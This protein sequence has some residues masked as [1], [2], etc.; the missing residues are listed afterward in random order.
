[1]KK[2]FLSLLFVTAVS[3]KLPEAFAQDESSP[4]L[5]N[6]PITQVYTPMRFDDN[7]NAQIIVEG[8][9][10]NTCFKVGPAKL[11]VNREEQKVQF[12]LMAIKYSGP[13]LQI[14]TPYIKVIDL[15]ILPEGKYEIISVGKSSP[16]AVL[17]VHHTDSK[18]AD[19]FLYAPVD[20]A[21]VRKAEGGERRVLT[22]AGTFPNSCMKFSDDVNSLLAHATNK[23]IIEVLPIVEM[24]KGACLQVNIP[25][26][27]SVT[28]EDNIKPG[29]YLIH[30]RTLNGQSFNKVD[31]IGDQNANP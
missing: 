24:E 28:L 8:E 5:V 21:F 16:A 25:F 11:K 30:I 6:A 4:T 26:T 14:Q 7:D 15:G 12:Q 20:A 9:F 23:N 13:C 3:S 1:M 18:M 19:D 22:V 10:P 27:R 29:K 31:F 17:S 2:L